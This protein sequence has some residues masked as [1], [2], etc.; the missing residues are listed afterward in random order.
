MSAQLHQQSKRILYMLKRE[1]GGPIDIYKLVDSRTDV[2]TGQ[3]TVTTNVYHIRRAI[4]MPAGWSRVRMSAISSANKD[5]V[6]GGAHDTN[7]RDFIVDRKDAPG[8]TL[9]PDD[10]IVCKGRKYQMSKVEAFE[11]DSGWIIT[12]K[13]SVGEVP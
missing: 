9:T 7:I 5:C 6:A 2:Q 13:E 10:W 3:K 1:Y 12:A 11:F 8:L 4:I